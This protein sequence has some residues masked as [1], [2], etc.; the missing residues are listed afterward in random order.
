MKNII[1]TA[2]LAV[3]FSAHASFYQKYCSNAEG[4]I[5]LSNGHMDNAVILTERA[6]GNAGVN[7]QEIEY[8]LGSLIIDRSDETEIENTTRTTCQ[9]GSTGG[10]VSW[11]KITTNKVVIKNADGSMFPDTTIGID[12]TRMAVKATVICEF[13][14]NSRTSCSN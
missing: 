10:M 5:K 4:T 9:P 13:S 2:I 6:Y 12:G 11:N 14:G 8:K 7:T 1:M 3:S